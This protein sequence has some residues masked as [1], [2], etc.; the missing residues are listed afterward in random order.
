MEWRD[1]QHLTCWHCG[2]IHHFHTDTLI[3][4]M[5]KMTGTGCKMTDA[6]KT[7]RS[8]WEEMTDVAIMQQQLVYIGSEHQGNHGRQALSTAT[9]NDPSVCCVRVSHLMRSCLQ[10]YQQKHSPLEIWPTLGK[11]WEEM[12]KK[13]M[14]SPLYLL[15]THWVLKKHSHDSLHADG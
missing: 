6:W 11:Q 4:W 12:E 2:D 14:V 1:Y 13:A 3:N 7:I 10:G 9:W 5:K 15:I 8:W